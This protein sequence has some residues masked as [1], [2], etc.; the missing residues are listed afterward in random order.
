MNREI[1][2]AWL[3]GTIECDGHITINKQWSG[4]VGLTQRNELFI[5]N[6]IGLVHDL[7]LPEPNVNQPTVYMSSYTLIWAAM[8]GTLLLQAVRPY[9]RHPYKMARADIY[10]KFFKLEDLYRKRISEED[11]EERQLLFEEFKKQQQL[12]KDEKTQEPNRIE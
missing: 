2:L 10:L 11:R 5:R 1:C 6:V 4:V 8:N 9:F 12:E 3:A 7:G